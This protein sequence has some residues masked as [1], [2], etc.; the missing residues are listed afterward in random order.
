M[1]HFNNSFNSFPSFDTSWI[2]YTG[3]ISPLFYFPPFRPLTWGGI[4]N[5]ANWIICKGLCKK[6]GDRANSRLGKSYSDMFR[7]KIRLGDSQL[8]TAHLVLLKV[9]NEE[10]N[11]RTR[12]LCYHPEVARH[13]VPLPR[14]PKPLYCHGCHNARLWWKLWLHGRHKGWDE[15]HHS[16]HIVE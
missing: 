5:W 16:A 12:C 13:W 10:F 7:A 9:H 15:H 1:V 6:I 3:K 2:L 11:L 8:Y 14:C 4:F